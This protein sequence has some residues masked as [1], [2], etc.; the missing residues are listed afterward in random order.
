VIRHPPLGGALKSEYLQTLSRH[1]Q[2]ERN[3]CNNH[4]AVAMSKPPLY[5]R[6]GNTP[7]TPNAKE[8]K[9]NVSIGNSSDRMAVGEV[10]TSYDYPLLDKAQ[11]F[12]MFALQHVEEVRQALL[13]NADDKTLVV[14]EGD[15]Y[16]FG[17]KNGAEISAA[18]DELTAAYEKLSS[19][20]WDVAR[21]EFEEMNCDRTRPIFERSKGLNSKNDGKAERLNK[22]AVPAID[23][24]IEGTR[25]VKDHPWQDYD[26]GSHCWISEAFIKAAIS[27]DDDEGGDSFPNAEFF[28][29]IASTAN[30][31]SIPP[32]FKMSEL[33]NEGVEGDTD[34]E[35]VD[36]S[37]NVKPTMQQSLP[38]ISSEVSSLHTS[39]PLNTDNDSHDDHDSVSDYSDASSS[40]DEVP[41]LENF[42]YLYKG[43]YAMQV[44]G[45]KETKGVVPKTVKRVLVDL[46]VKR[47]EEGAFQGCNS[48][49]SITI[50]QSVEEVGNHAFR[51]CSRLKTVTFLT[52]SSKLRGRKL[53]SQKHDEKK[54]EKEAYCSASSPSSNTEPR[55]SQLRTI[56]EWAFFN[57]SALASVNL[58]Y[59]LRS[60][61]ARAF[62]RCSSMSITELPKTLTS[63]GENAFVG[64]PL[65]TKAALLRWEKDQLN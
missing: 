30:A 4:I 24:T 22:I 34:E 55:S 19:L 39:S 57:C 63:V 13:S 2:V 53:Q 31:T 33:L 11:Q 17:D 8:I 59:G 50:P 44:S 60:I 61:G 65:G 51:K 43:G 40:S 7:P 16:S 10:N 54:E 25:G 21:M 47:I 58:P 5:S 49:E 48:L 14:G 45:G 32:G 37:A 3:S 52:K 35:Q 41:S 42:D 36:D 18:F 9:R 6:T 29:M 20:K 46:S 38:S 1:H 64:T 15:G 28:P 27:S 12:S 26:I 56:G 62:Q 23:E